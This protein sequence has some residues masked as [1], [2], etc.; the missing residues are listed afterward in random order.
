MEEEE[1]KEENIWKRQLLNG[2]MGVVKEGSNNAK[3]Q[4]II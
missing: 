4:K 2:N 3:Y 1:Q